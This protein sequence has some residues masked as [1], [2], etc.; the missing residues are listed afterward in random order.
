MCSPAGS[1]TCGVTPASGRNPANDTQAMA[2]VWRDGQRKVVYIY[3]LLLT[4]TIEEK[5]Y[6]RQLTKQA[7]SGAVVG[8]AAG[9]AKD[10]SRSAFTLEELRDLFTLREDTLCDTHELLG[11][12]CVADAAAQPPPASVHRPVRVARIARRLRYD[13]LA[14]ADAVR[15]WHSG[16]QVADATR[17]GR[18][19]S[20]ACEHGSIAC[21]RRFPAMRCNGAVPGSGPTR[22]VTLLMRTRHQ[23]VRSR[24]WWRG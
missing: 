1:L 8:Q 17:D 9:G 22:S 15:A 5:I 10:A 13:R 18:S 12:E 20:A 14:G 24:I 21:R 16:S 23:R 2:R 3:R 19:T 6:Q 4:G 11:C 7:L